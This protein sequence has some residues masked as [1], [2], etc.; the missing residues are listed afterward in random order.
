MSEIA[1][2]LA[3]NDIYERLETLE[4]ME[5]HNDYILKVLGEWVSKLSDKIERPIGEEK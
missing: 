5:R 2:R 4:R 1:T 3:L